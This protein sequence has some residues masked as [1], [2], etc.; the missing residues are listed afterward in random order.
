MENSQKS[1]ESSDG[2]PSKRFRVGGRTLLLGAGAAALLIFIIQN[3]QDV[4][5][6]FLIADFTWPL[7]LYTIFIAAIGA[8]VWFGLGVL[9]RHRRR[10][11]RREGRRARRG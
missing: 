5:F 1:L 7:W 6:H 8:L 4:R 3:R 2:Q 9:R 11:D 10:V